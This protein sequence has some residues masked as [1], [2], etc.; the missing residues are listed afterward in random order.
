M[1]PGRVIG[2]AAACRTCHGVVAFTQH[3]AGTTPSFTACKLGALQK[4]YV[5]DVLYVCCSF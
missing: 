1:W 5:R 2:L 4:Y 3:R